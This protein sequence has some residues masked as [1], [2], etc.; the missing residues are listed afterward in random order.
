[1]DKRKSLTTQ[2]LRLFWRSMRPHRL[3]MVLMVV[4]LV[5]AVIV[6]SILPALLYREIINVLASGGSD[7]GALAREIYVII[8]K[9]LALNLTALVLWRAVTFLDNFFGTRV[10]ADL[11][12]EAFEYIH[13]HSQGFFI[14]GFVGSFV[15]KINRFAAA[16]GRLEGKVFWSLMPTLVTV[17]SIFVV[18]A[19]RSLVLSVALVVWAVV[20]SVCMY[21]ASVYKMRLEAVAAAV[22][23]DVA[24]RV[25]DTITNNTNIKLFGS[26]GRES[27]DFR[28]LTEAQ[29]R[30]QKKVYD[31]DGLI[32]GVQ[33]G[34]MVA[35]EFVVIRLAVG[36]WARGAI[37]IGDFALIQTYLF[38]LFYRFW[39]IGR[40]VRDV[41]AQIADAREM[42]EIFETPHEVVD[43]PGA[44]ELQVTRGEI[45]YRDVDFTY[46]K[47]R[48]VM[49]GFSLDI[50]PGEKVGIVGP[51]GAGKSTLVS[52]LFRFYDLSGG[53]IEIDGQN[54]AHVTQ[55]SLRRQISLVPQ[56]PVLFHRTLKE[57]IRYA[58]PEATDDE[59]VAAA[60][61]A[62]C[63]EFI[64]RMPEGYDTFVG[65]R[66]VK[67]SG[68]E[69]QRVAIARAMLA[70]AP[71]LVLDEATSSLDSESE[72]AIQDAFGELMRGK[73][74]LVIAH[75]LSTIMKMDRIV[76]V[77][78]GRVVE[79]GTHAE[80][81]AREGGLYRRLWDLQAGGFLK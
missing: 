44:R 80:L 57:N 74:V 6:Q 56:D 63:D 32:E 33:A 52:L 81:L 10:I 37:T 2:T 51:S 79:Q 72:R 45:V 77:D 15:R 59:V 24:G 31:V 27:A 28:A 29:F 54:I 62:H 69:R 67:L 25:A 49:S 20:Y 19:S 61:A 1:M 68:G 53:R 30:M 65:E 41:Y 18:L 7:R 13:R 39:D 22:D 73:T 40:V 23:S 11:T 47:T 42:T 48:A 12:N 14:K 35:I 76:V 75:R 46:T 5:C 50:K 66:G 78:G 26:L 60:R 64:T 3:I 43:T 70:A 38:E 55:D 36:L 9:L 58:R 17:I 34:L 21:A 4:G 8:W 71:I 16:F